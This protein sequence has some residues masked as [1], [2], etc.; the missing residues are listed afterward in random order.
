MLDKDSA[1]GPMNSGVFMCGTPLPPYSPL[2]P[3]R[4][5]NVSS[6][7]YNYR[8][9]LWRRRSLCHEKSSDTVQ[10]EAFTL[11]ETW[12]VAQKVLN[13]AGILVTLALPYID[14]QRE[15]S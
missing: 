7:A 15:A 9:I 6:L 3:A 10:H 8:Y 1:G 12:Y 11:N 5:K 14:G 13:S 2:A 4:S